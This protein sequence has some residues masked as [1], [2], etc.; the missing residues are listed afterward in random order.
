VYNSNNIDV[1]TNSTCTRVSGN[2]T[3]GVW[4]VS[5][6][7]NSGNNPGS[8]SVRASATDTSGNSSPLTSVGSFSILGPLV[9]N[10]GTL[11]I[12]RTIGINYVDQI[13]LNG[14]DL[15][16]FIA[17]PGNYTW[18]VRVENSAGSIV[19][20]QAVGSNQ[21]YITGLSSSTTYKVYLV[22]TDYSGG[23]K[24][25]T[26][27]TITTLAPAWTPP[28]NLSTPI[29]DDTY[30]RICLTQN[31][32][33]CGN[34][35]IYNEVGTV[36]N[37]LVGPIPF[38]FC[39]T[40]GVNV[41]SGTPKGYAV[42]T[43]Q[44]YAPIDTE[45][46]KLASNSGSIT[47]ASMSQGALGIST[48]SNFTV[49]FRAT[50]DIGVTV[51]N[52]VLD[53]SCCENVVQRIFL[54]TFA[55]LTS[56]TSKDGVYSATA[57]FPGKTEMQSLKQSWNQGGTEDSMKGCGKYY[58]RI[59]LSDAKNHTSWLTLGTINVVRCSE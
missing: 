2:A 31:W 17:S 40:S 6:N 20:S 41:C 8:Y 21:T 11:P 19:T 38:T 34:W 42:L 23:T 32:T 4:Q 49:N 25:S 50:D 37:R 43:G 14:F 28:A 30:T 27:L 22:A 36:V 45:L 57:L 1:V 12:P 26:A 46:P 55:N 24:L 47:S 59:M 58:I 33:N 51:A 10:L 9:S 48:N 16:N 29:Y 53:T 54:S 18:A 56:G 13:V 3:D 15:G 5:I 7:M 35:T 52:M 44:Y 39:Q